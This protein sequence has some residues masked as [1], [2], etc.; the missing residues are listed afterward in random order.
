MWHKGLGGR[1]LES[2]P[3][4]PSLGGWIT[5]NFRIGVSSCGRRRKQTPLPFFL[6]PSWSA[7]KPRS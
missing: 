6:H 5:A 7:G 3:W 4:D 1:S 2:C